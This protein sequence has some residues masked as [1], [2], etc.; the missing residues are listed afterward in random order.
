MLKSFPLSVHSVFMKLA[1]VIVCAIVAVV[2]TLTFVMTSQLDRI[3]DDAV[4]QQAS[5]ETRL[6]AKPMA[7]PVRFGKIDAIAEQ[8]EE[9]IVTSGDT[10]RDIAVLNAQ[11]DVVAYGTAPPTD[12]ARQIAQAAMATGEFQHD[13]ARNLTA[14]PLHFGQDAAVI[15]AVVA[16]WSAAA[17]AA[18]TRAS[19]NA[20]LSIAAAVCFLALVAA[21]IAIKQLAIRPLRSA[22]ADISRLQDRDFVSVPD[23]I[24]RKDE[25]GAVARAADALRHDLAEAEGANRESAFK[26]AALDNTS[27]ALMILDHGFSITQISPKLKALFATHRDGLRKLHSGFDPESVVGMHMDEFYPGGAITDRMLGLGP[28]GIETLLKLD[29]TRIVVAIHAVPDAGGDVAGFVVEWRDVTE[30][31]RQQA[32]IDTIDRIQI[33]A[34]FAM[35]G[36][37][38]HSNARFTECLSDSSTDASR[39]QDLIAP[40]S[41][42]RA[43]SVDSILQDLRSGNPHLGKIPILAGQSARIIDGSLSCI[44]DEDGTGLRF[45]LLGTDITDQEQQ[46]EAARR[47]RDASE[48]EKS[49]VVDALGVG[50]RK[51]SDGD[52]TVTIPQAFPGQYEA[53]RND[54]NQTVKNLARAM[55]DIA[56]SAENIRNESGDITNTADSLS[57]RTEST[58]ATLEQTAAALDGLTGALKSAA[59]GAARADSVV[60]EAHRKAEASGEVVIQT[61]SAMDLIARSSAQITSIIRVIDD[62]AFQT[63][64]LALNAGVEAARAGE[65][66]R[67]FAVVASEVRALAQRSSDAAREINGLIA[68]SGG[69]V[70]K[71]VELVGQTG[72]ALQEIVTSVTEIAGLVSEIADSAQAQ[73]LSLEEINQSVNDLDQSTQQN[74]ARLEETTAASEALRNDAVSLVKTLSHFRTGSSARPRAAAKA[75]TPRVAAAGGTSSAPLS[76]SQLSGEAAKW[77]DF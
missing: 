59:A 58:A 67:G 64:L 10:L 3:V 62:I 60:G 74:A 9:V 36:E 40:M 20:A 53:L 51:L 33:K 23:G 68:D 1:L 35:T 28:D 45:L 47:E 38:V 13:L 27:A 48:A 63:N 7:G 49:E 65:A 15:G 55:R 76:A 19:I 21:T 56:D 37:C 25:F 12:P 71:G 26:S 22:Q 72:Q 16:E 2:A 73:S 17:L 57:R 77:M 66:G 70:K 42:G 61:V 14:A 69:Q 32:L 30:L 34:E 54:F 44:R 29:D 50:L 75:Q 11:Q 43:R 52:L 18:R 41:T 4:D 46:M 8:I 6:I 5:A 24:G 31:W 39:L